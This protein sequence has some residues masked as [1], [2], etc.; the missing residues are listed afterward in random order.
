VIICVLLCELI[1]LVCH[2]SKVLCWNILLAVLQL[3][4]T[5]SNALCI[6]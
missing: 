1:K 5:G 3:L 6:V 4:E 2:V